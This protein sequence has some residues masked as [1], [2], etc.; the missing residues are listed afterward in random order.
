MNKLPEKLVELRKHYGYS[1]NFLAEKLGIET[2]DYMGYENGRSVPNFQE[3][4]ILA[5]LYHL[6][7]EDLF[8]N[9]RQII[10]ETKKKNDV[11]LKNYQY[12]TNQ[13]KKEAVIEKLKKNKKKI[14]IGALVIVTLVLII[15]L[16]PHAQNEEIF[17]IKELKGTDMLDAS[18]T[19]VVYVDINKKASGRGDNSNNQLDFDFN[20]IVKVE[21]GAT[22]TVGLR[23]DGTLV[24]SG[25]LTKYADEISTWTNIID[26]ELGNGHIVALNNKGQVLCTGSNSYDQ[27]ELSGSENIVDIF[28]TKNATFI[29]DVDGNL[30]YSGDFIGKSLINELKDVIAIAASDNIMAYVDKH[31]YVT[32]Y[33]DY[34]TFPLVSNWT[35]I[36]D[37]AVG[38]EFIAALDKSGRVYIDI[39]NYKISDEV[40][41]WKDIIAIAAGKDYLVAF[42]GNNL[43][44]VGNNAYNQFDVVESQK[45]TLPSVSN[46]KIERDEHNLIITFDEVVNA[47]EYRLQMDVGAGIA[48]RSSEP[49]FVIELNRLEN[50]KNY[51][52]EIVAIGSDRYDNSQPSSTNYK[53]I[54]EEEPEVSE[55]P[56]VEIEIP[57][58]L[59]MLEGKSKASFEAY[60]KGF[61]VMDDKLIA[62]ETEIPCESG[63]EIILGV[64]GITNYQSITKSELLEKEIHYYYCKVGD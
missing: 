63:E 29:K 45:L 6:E 61:G 28:A 22:F 11:D 21:E 53:Y 24:S 50:E 55:T 38:D 23:S 25:L 56:K 9:D 36:I 37:I 10:L 26:I 39:D 57:F 51:T 52:I 49:K 44:G 14:G 54:K 48:V 35:N 13:A 42:D 59:D 60:L 16:L 64:S 15:C 58:T 7:I 8:I 30:K 18:D 2:I 27:C 41:N 1:Q 43:Y 4:K 19:T 5:K 12:Y 17:L 47:S 40:N 20:D 3:I 34:Q 33:T 46:I 31:G 62:H 32:Y